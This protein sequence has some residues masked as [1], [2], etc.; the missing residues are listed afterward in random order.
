MLQFSLELLL[1]GLRMLIFLT[2]STGPMEITKFSW[3]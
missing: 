1:I 2:Q 3:T